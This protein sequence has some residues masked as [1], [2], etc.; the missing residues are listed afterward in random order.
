[1]IRRV[2]EGRGWL[3]L[4]GEGGSNPINRVGSPSP[5]VGMGMV[6]DEGGEEIGEVGEGERRW[7][8]LAHP[9]TLSRSGDGSDGGGVMVM[10]QWHVLLDLSR[11]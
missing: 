11:F 3:I 5:E 2:G 4:G 7:A 6:T 1:V 10:C 8:N 9:L